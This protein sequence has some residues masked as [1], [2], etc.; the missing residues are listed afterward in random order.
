MELEHIK[1]TVNSDSILTDNFSI[2]NLISTTPESVSECFNPES[3]DN[4]PANSAFHFVTLKINNVS[5]K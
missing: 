3:F 1:L 5:L 2:E 4:Q